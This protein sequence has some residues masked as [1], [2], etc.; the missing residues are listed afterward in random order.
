M[1]SAIVNEIQPINYQEQQE[2]LAEAGAK[3]AAR[4]GLALGSRTIHGDVATG[5]MWAQQN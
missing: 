5:P 2:T 1:S 4:C 3:A